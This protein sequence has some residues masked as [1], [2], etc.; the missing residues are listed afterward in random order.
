LLVQII[1]WILTYLL[2]IPLFT[3][4][5]MISIPST[6]AIVFIITDH[7]IK[8]EARS[9][10]VVG[11]LLIPLYVFLYATVYSIKVKKKA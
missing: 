6:W 5:S 2:K 4:I 10:L 3:A 7:F 8:I 1:L 11:L 9:N